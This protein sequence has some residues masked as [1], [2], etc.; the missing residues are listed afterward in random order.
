MSEQTLSTGPG[1]RIIMLDQALGAVPYPAETR[2]DGNNFGYVDLI[3]H[4]ERVNLVME[5]REWSGIA[6]L[7]KALNAVG[8][9]FL[10]TASACEFVHVPGSPGEPEIVVAAYVGIAFR[11]PTMNHPNR[12]Q[13]LAEALALRLSKPPQPFVSIDLVVAPLT[14]FFGIR[15]CF[16]L[17]MRIQAWGH[18][19]DDAQ[20]C[21]D[22]V[23]T[24]IATGIQDINASFSRMQSKSRSVG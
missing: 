15:G 16:E 2:A 5:A 19:K 9:P 12:H 24:R 20:V 6:R 1:Y 21:F 18:G 4:P 10:S 8:S 7:L 14:H 3:D 22:A 17:E 11:S 13:R 23:A